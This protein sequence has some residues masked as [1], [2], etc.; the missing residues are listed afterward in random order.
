MTTTENQVPIL[1]RLRPPAGA[2]R[3]KK[4]KGRGA[5]SGLGKTAGKGQKGQKARHPGDF[6]KLHFEGGQTPMQR[7]LPKMGFKPLNSKEYAI[8]NL[9]S[10]EAFDAG[11]T[12]DRASLKDAGLIRR[13]PA[14]IKILGGGELSK[15]L[16][17]KA[18]A[19]SKSAK[20]KIEKAGGQAI[21]I[22][23]AAKKTNRSE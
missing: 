12:V 16:T 19:F 1:S 20:E 14:P 7:R 13:T 17:V 11:S 10:L 23:A 4:R 3:N 6:G 9:L 8:V 15:A 21:V 18:E 5:G 22:E 2:V